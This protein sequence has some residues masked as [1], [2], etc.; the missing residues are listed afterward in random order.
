MNRFGRVSGANQPVVKLLCVKKYTEKFIL[1][2]GSTETGWAAAFG[3]NSLCLFAGLI[4]CP[5]KD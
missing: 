4:D 1:T 5:Q 2:S 3:F